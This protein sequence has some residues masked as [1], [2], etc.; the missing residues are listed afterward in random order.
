MNQIVDPQGQPTQGPENTP[1]RV[2]INDLP[3]L[4]CGSCGAALWTQAYIVKRVSPIQSPTGKEE[5][6]TIP[7]L[8]CVVCKQALHSFELMA[9]QQ[10]QDQVAKQEAP[11]EP[12]AAEPE[13]VAT[14]AEPEAPPV[15]V[16]AAPAAPEKPQVVESQPEEFQP[17]PVG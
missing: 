5:H 7:V 12:E 8:V 6:V 14:P 10:L 2:N 1:V 17:K 15:E 3:S 11:A 4:T 13:K 9:Q 16:A